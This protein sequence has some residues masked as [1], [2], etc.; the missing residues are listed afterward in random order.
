VRRVITS[1]PS[2]ELERVL[3]FAVNT[4]YRP[5]LHDWVSWAYGVK[6][7]TTGVADLTFR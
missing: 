3:P 2:I 7:N 6:R 5:E 4:A 1:P